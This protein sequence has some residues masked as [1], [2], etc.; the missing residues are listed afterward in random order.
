MRTTVTLPEPLLQN[1]KRRA[2]ER[3]VTLSALI[4]DALRIHL[5]G[6]KP[7]R[8]EAFRLFTVRGRLVDPRLDLDRTSAL[9]SLDDETRFPGPER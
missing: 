1:A 2:S 6:T 9:I 7:P 4:E 3:G 8:A 5:A